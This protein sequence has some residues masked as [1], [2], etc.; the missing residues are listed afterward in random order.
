MEKIL[1]IS[2]IVLFIIALCVG[3][4]L[5]IPKKNVGDSNVSNITSTAKL[6]ED[7]NLEEVS[8]QIDKNSITNSSVTLI[9]T[10]N[11][12]IAYPWED[13]YMIQRK[14]DGKWVDVEPKG[15]LLTSGLSH[16]KDENNQY[17]QRINWIYCYGELEN[18]QYRIV[19]PI[20]DSIKLYSEE[21]EINE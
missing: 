15:D 4:V 12:E 11:S 13:S 20:P 19:K 8:L 3:I 2:I 14:I 17:I 10:D 1:Y 9:I 7:R 5:I 6:N 18:G 16:W 21:F